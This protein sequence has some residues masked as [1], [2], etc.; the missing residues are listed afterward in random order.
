MAGSIYVANTTAET[1]LASSSQKC[2][3]RL[4]AP[5]SYQVKIKEWGVYFDGVSSVASPI[6]VQL[7]L[8]D[9]S[10]GYYTSHTPTKRAGRPVACQSV[11][12][13]MNTSSDP[14]IFSVLAIREVHPQAG[15]QEKFAYGEEPTLY[16]PTTV[17]GSVVSL[18][19][20]SPTSVYALGEIVFEE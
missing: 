20:N 17:A 1:L 11:V 19:V 6:V 13:T 9:T 18:I 4:I 16:G 5:S 7:C 8:T 3:I 2:L 14:T 12:Q 10:F 15:Y